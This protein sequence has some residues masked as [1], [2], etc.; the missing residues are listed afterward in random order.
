MIVKTTNA[1]RPTQHN[2]DA[3]YIESTYLQR[4][5]LKCGCFYNS[6]VRP[7]H[8]VQKLLFDKKKLKKDGKWYRQQQA[9][10]VHKKDTSR[11]CC[12][13]TYLAPHKYIKYMN[14]KQNTK[15][16]KDRKTKLK[17]NTHTQILSSTTD[18]NKNN[19]IICS[20]NSEEINGVNEKKSNGIQY[21]KYSSWKRNEI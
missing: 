7:Q 18:K 5:W 3:F 15:A 20:S 12:A 2:F 21:R 6:L 9:P 16:S 1:I 13:H 19:T 10:T 14:Q 8:K 17:K 11:W 4:K